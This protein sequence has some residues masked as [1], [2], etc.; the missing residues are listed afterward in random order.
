MK[1]YFLLLITFSFFSCSFQNNSENKKAEILEEEIF[2]DSRIDFFLEDLNKLNINRVSKYCII[3]K[4]KNFMIGW[5]GKEG[6]T[7]NIWYVFIDVKKF[8]YKKYPDLY[9]LDLSENTKLVI[10]E[11]NNNID[12]S[13]YKESNTDII[14]INLH[15]KKIYDSLISCIDNNQIK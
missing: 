10:K 7:G 12:L 9:D 2:S 6:Q 11:I 8:K 4:N 14:S 3:Q 5:E 15:D 1:K 13:D